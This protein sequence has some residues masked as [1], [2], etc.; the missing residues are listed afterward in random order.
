MKIISWNVNGLRAI[1]RKDGFLDFLKKEK[2]DMLCLQE[3]KASEEQLPDELRSIA[4]YYAYFA[5]SKVKKGYSGVAIYTKE[6]PTK[7]EYGL[8]IKK[9]DDEGRTL[10]VHFKNFVL[11]NVYFPNGGGGPDRLQYK[12]DFYDAF[13]AYIEKL[14]KKEKKIIFCGDVNTAHEAID[15][16]RPKENEKNT[17]FLPEER[18]WIDE[19]IAQGFVDVFRHFY[20]DKT[21]AYTYWD[22]KTRARDRNVGWRID[23]FFVSNILS[24]K[25][26]AIKI[27]SEVYGSDHCPVTME[28]K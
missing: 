5:S 25:I 9:F 22:M 19:V 18:A 28:I 11:L 16:A 3:T 13:L 17:G 21:G 20:P 1:H 24:T 4:G 7:V 14:R 27:L 15:L 10:V 23:Y 12:L 6:K 26:T 8:G 2:P